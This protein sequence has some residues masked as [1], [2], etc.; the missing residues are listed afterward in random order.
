MFHFF[1]LHYDVRSRISPDLNNWFF[2]NYVLTFI[3]VF[4]SLAGHTASVDPFCSHRRW[5][6]SSIRRFVNFVYLSDCFYFSN[7]FFLLLLS[8]LLLSL[9]LLRS[10]EYNRTFSFFL[11]FHFVEKN[12]LIFSFLFLH[13]CCCC[14][15]SHF[16]FV[17]LSSFCIFFEF[18]VMCHIGS[19]EQQIAIWVYKTDVA[20]PFEMDNRNGI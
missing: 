7:I 15:L 4:H 6:H 20:I 18:D 13:C 1:Q 3:C 9:L 2:V 17:K 10:F 12:F 16:Y 19:Y 8:L 5:I 11:R 14:S